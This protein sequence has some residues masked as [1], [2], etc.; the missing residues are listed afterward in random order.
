MCTCEASQYRMLLP[1]EMEFDFSVPDALENCQTKLQVLN[2]RFDAHRQEIY[3][4]LILIG[5]HLQTIQEAHN[6]VL[7]LNCLLLFVL[8]VFCGLYIWNRFFRTV[9]IHAKKESSK[10]GQ[11]ME[12]LALGLV[13]L[14]LDIEETKGEMNRQF[15]FLIRHKTD[16]AKILEIA[17]NIEE[18]LE[19]VREVTLANSK[20]FDVLDCSIASMP[21]VMGEKYAEVW[22]GMTDMFDRMVRIKGENKDSKPQRPMMG[23]RE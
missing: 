13:Q 3:R 7:Y 23:R 20:R 14:K 17:E 10:L 22:N 11:K 8:V 9:T 2:D 1:E 16:G 12:A 5:K 15:S 19:I 6:W 4:H 18:T 21:P